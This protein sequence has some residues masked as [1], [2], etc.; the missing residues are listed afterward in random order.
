MGKTKID[1]AKLGGARRKNGHKFTCTC[2]IC[3]NMKNKAKRGGYT[4][5]MEKQQEYINGG[6]KKKNGHRKECKCP[7]CKNMNNSKKNKE[8][9]K[10]KTRKLRGGN[11]EDD[12]EDKITDDDSSDNEEDE[13]IGGK[14]KGNGHKMSCKCPICQNMRKSKSKK[15]GQELN[16]EETLAKDEEYEELENIQSSVGGKRKK[17]S[18]KKR[19]TKTKRSRRNLK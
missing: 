7:I 9:G 16:K 6:Y 17:T 14:K 13:I 11:D 19:N 12:E 8:G 3:E 15:G 4:E 2:H 1:E 10:R 18:F 5:E